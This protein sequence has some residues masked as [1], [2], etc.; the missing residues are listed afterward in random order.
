MK[1]S[2]RKFKSA[3][4]IIGIGDEGKNA[5]ALAKTIAEK[6]VLVEVVK[7]QPSQSLSGGGVEARQVR[8]KLLALSGENVRFKSS[9]VVS[10]NPW[11]D[12]QG[13]LAAEKPGILISEW[14][15]GKTALGT[16]DVELLTSAPCDIVIVRGA[17]NL[18]FERTLIAVRGGPYAELALRV[19]LQLAPLQLDVLHLSLGSGGQGDAAFAGMKRILQNIPEA[20]LISR[21]TKDFALTVFEEAE[22]YNAVVLG[23]TAGKKMGLKTIGPVAEKLLR[24]SSA[25]VLIVKTC[26]TLDESEFDESAGAQA[27]SVLVD[28]WFAENTFHSDEFSDLNRLVE[29][30]QQQGVSISLALPAL[31]EEATVEKVITTIKTAL[32]EKTPLLDEIVLMDSNSTD[33]TREI[34]TGLG[35][36]VYIHQEL[37][38]ELGART[39]KGE[40]LWKSLLVTRGDIIAWIDTDIVNFHPR[41]VYGIIG[42][43]LVNA[44]IQFTK[45]FY[46]RPLRVGGK[47]QAGGGGRVTE[48][49]ARPLLNL[50]YPELSGVIQ[51]LSGE[52]AGRR[53]ALEKVNFCSGYGVETSLLVDIFEE[54]GLRAI[55]QVDL[56][57]RVHHNQDLEAL[58]KMSFVIMQTMLRKLEKRYERAIIEDVNKTM[59]MI[60]YA[61]GN[62]FLDVEMLP[63]MERPPMISL[64]QYKERKNR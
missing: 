57:E 2:R 48:L 16:S 63:E 35:I 23:A 62:Y 60:R 47:T 31:N 21:E 12:L 53:S 33:R 59:K 50:F 28:K 51:P 22:K 24:E 11:R 8:K 55:A 38:P 19:G 40:A 41:F 15:D 27:I 34:A 42:P 49:T 45:G 1:S 39:G 25:T 61:N 10:E 14:H 20:N 6:V 13:V 44:D 32:M 46:R 18:N 29:L 54:Y 43:L 4:V 56:L 9:I 36:P 17:K 30:K 26:R 3:L 64:P 7:I 58:S 37:L 5:L 52:Y